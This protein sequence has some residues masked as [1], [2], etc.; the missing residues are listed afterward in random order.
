MDPVVWKYG[1]WIA[2]ARLAALWCMV[3]GFRYGDWR[4]L[5]AYFLTTLILPEL[6][7]LRNLRSDQPRWIADLAVLTFFASYLY[8]WL[9]ARLLRR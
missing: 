7:L 6:M 8:A 3:T 9:V 5:P 1:S 4:Q 2:A